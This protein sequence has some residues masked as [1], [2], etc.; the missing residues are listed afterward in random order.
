MV[1]FD[2]AERRSRVYMNKVH[3]GHR[4]GIIED[5]YGIR[6]VILHVI[7]AAQILIRRFPVMM[8]NAFQ[9]I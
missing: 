7:Q 9:I 1:K 6:L 3:T 4:R 8:E 2:D 5:G